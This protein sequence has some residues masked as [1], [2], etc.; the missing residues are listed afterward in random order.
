MK[1]QALKAFRRI[2]DVTKTKEKLSTEHFG[3]TWAVGIAIAF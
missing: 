3:G 2:V 1:N